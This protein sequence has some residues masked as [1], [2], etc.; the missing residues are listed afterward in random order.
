MCQHPFF[1]CPLSYSE[2]EDGLKYECE[3]SP[4]FL[5]Q[6]YSL[7]ETVGNLC[8]L[9]IVLVKL[10]ILLIKGFDLIVNQIIEYIFFLV[11]R[12]VKCIL[13]C[14]YCLDHITTYGQV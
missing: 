11:S 3:P 14:C 8:T 12:D 2:R 5:P 13:Y 7:P 10:L 4:I 1:V 9:V 6:E